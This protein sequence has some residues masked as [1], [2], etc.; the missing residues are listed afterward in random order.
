[1]RNGKRPGVVALMKEGGL[2]PET[3]CTDD[4]AFKAAP[5][6]NAAGRMLHAETA[7]SLLTTSDPDTAA[8]L[9][10][11]LDRLNVKRQETEK[12]FADMLAKKFYDHK[13]VVDVED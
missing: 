7:L 6:L 1:M 12:K 10:T 11:S 4:I 5:R 2:V 3:V 9:A 13:I 8:T